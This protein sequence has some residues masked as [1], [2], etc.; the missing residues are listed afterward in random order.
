MLV[1]AKF[2]RRHTSSERNRIQGWLQTRAK[3]K[4]IKL[5]VE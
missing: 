3:S 5:I 4:R 1:Y 2:S